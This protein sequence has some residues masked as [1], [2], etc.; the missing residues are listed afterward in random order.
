MIWKNRRASGMVSTEVAI[1]IGLTVAVLFIVLG[2]FSDNLKAMVTQSN[3]KSF[4]E[5]NDSKT[6]YSSFNRNYSNSVV[7]TQMV[8]EQGLEQMR[9]RANNKAIEKIESPFSDSNANANTIGY[10]AIAIQSMV[11]EPHVCTYMKKNSKKVCDKIDTEIGYKYNIKFNGDGV[12][13]SSVD[14][15]GNSVSKTIRLYYTESSVASLLGGGTSQGSTD[16]TQYDFIKGLTIALK[17]FVD[18]D[19]LLVNI[20]DYFTTGSAQAAEKTQG[21][22]AVLKRMFIDLPNTLDDA[23]NTCYGSLA[24]DIKRELDYLAGKKSKLNKIGNDCAPN[25][26]E[27]KA[28]YVNNWIKSVE[29]RV[30]SY[31][32][33]DTAGLINEILSDGQLSTVINYLNDDVANERPNTACDIFMNALNAVVANS[34][35]TIALPQC[36][37]GEEFD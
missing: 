5:G 17:P 30:N 20:I 6:F 27:D 19:A 36:N 33:S 7:E 23:H 14:A 11:G 8:G 22:T 29:S 10:L 4:F 15:S 32:G 25:I 13:I 1:S 31:T 3:V 16:E 26:S 21:A 18:S 37:P 35:S 2:L 24:K 34:G 28:E 9:K 12:T